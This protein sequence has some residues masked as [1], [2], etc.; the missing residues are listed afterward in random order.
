MDCLQDNATG[1][2]LG[3]P[4]AESQVRRFGTSGRS[5]SVPG[6]RDD[7]LQAMSNKSAFDKLDPAFMLPSTAGKHLIDTAPG[8][9]ASDN[10][11]DVRSSPSNV[12]DARDW[13]DASAGY[14]NRDT[15][16]S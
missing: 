10:R 14:G 5:R 7:S 2:E 8:S 13:Q 6:S 3:L 16:G 4:R 15:G 12:G 1:N 11:V 9:T